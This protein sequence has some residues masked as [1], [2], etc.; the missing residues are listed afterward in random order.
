MNAQTI[1]LVGDTQRQFAHRC[2]GE[3]PV[4]YVVTIREETRTAAQNRKM[5]PMLKDVSDQVDWYGKSLRP[6]D[7]KN[8]FTASLR[9]AQVVPSIDGDGFVTIGHS[10]SSMGK[11]E[12]CDLIELIYAFGAQHDVR[13]SEKSLETYRE[14]AQ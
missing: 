11:R 1:I 10:T 5:W 12:F 14:F 8:M 9:K 3:A 7:W 13:W 2:I 6:D 4:G